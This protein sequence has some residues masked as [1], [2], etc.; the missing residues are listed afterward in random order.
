MSDL[1]RTSVA[2]KEQILLLMDQGYSV[3]K[4]SPI[5]KVCRRTIRQVLN[6]S[7]FPKQ[8][9]E[10]NPSSEFDWAAVATQKAKGISFKTL[11][12]EFCP[13]WSYYRFYRAC[14][15]HL[16]KTTKTTLIL[17]HKPGEMVQV[18]YSEGLFV[19]DVESGER[20]KTQFFC[21]VLP[22]SSYTFGE[23][24]ASQKQTDFLNSQTR[25]FKFLGGVTPYVV[26]DNL[27]TGV[28][29]SHLY[30]PDLN[31]TY[32]E[33]A[34]HLGFAVLPAR[35]RHP[36]DKAAVESAIGVIQ[37]QFFQQ[38][39][40]RVFTNIFE[41]NQIF[42]EYLKQ[43]NKQVM[44]DYGLSR[45]ERFTP[46]KPLLK[47]L[48]AND[49]E[50]CQWQEATVHPDCHVQIL[51]N[52]YSV[53]YVYAGQRVKVRISSSMLEI[54]NEDRAIIAVHA[55]LTG[56]HQKS[57]LD[58]HY[59]EHKV[60]I[61]R[62]E[63]SHAKLMAQK[64]GPEMVRLVAQQF[65]NDRPLRN[66]RKVQGILRLKNKVSNEA[67]EYA[68]K[69]ALKFNRVRVKYLQDCAQ[70]YQVNGPRLALVKPRREANEIYVHQTQEGEKK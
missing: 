56:R 65:D 21:G 44:K 66:L 47:A 70:H 10:P 62:F 61:T 34:N 48:P 5:L 69:Q 17:Q 7:Q 36:R 42:S 35:P 59:P 28:T 40:E 20:I 24:T 12:A 8:I 60:A 64:I 54:F 9:P 23:F 67:L 13:D 57:T 19:L 11:N 15:K 1:S 39:R 30:D 32:C 45:E 33:Y 26:I 22:F 49:F 58:A 38:Y 55:R 37:R 3:R 52:L 46:E 50:L 51:H 18:D 6:T 2:M 29:R 63:I 68:C 16:V 25:M 4:I 43:F 14:R 31:P 53:P 27:K 41:L